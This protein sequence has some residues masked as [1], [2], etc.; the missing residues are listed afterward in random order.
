[1]LSSMNDLGKGS[2]VGLFEYFN[3]VSK[4]EDDELHL[5]VVFIPYD[6]DYNKA[7]NQ[8]LGNYLMEHLANLDYNLIR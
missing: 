2:V 3:L 4:D 8:I 5:D 7:V 6:V 1:M